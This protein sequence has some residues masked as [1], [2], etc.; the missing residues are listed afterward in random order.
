MKKSFAIVIVCYNRI[1]GVKR[2]TQSLE[3][4]DFDGRN[5]ID[6][7]FSI[8]NSGSNIVEKFAANYQ[9]KNGKKIIRT[10]EKRQG[11]KKH[12]LQCG[13]YTNDYDILVVLED[14]IFVSDSMYHFAY[15]AAVYYWDDT[16]VAGISLY[17]FQK[18][19]LKW[20][21]RFEPQKTKYDTY[22][23]RI[24]MSWGQVWTKPKWVAFKSWLLMNESFEKADDIPDVLNVWPETS[25]LKYH[26]L[27]CI[28]ENKYFVYPYVS[29]STNY[30]DVGEHA[31]YSVTDHQ[32]E[33]M[34]GKKDYLFPLNDDDAVCYDEFMEREG[35]GKYMGID[36][37][38]LTVDLW[39]NKPKKYYKKYVLSIENLPFKQIET[40]ALALRPI[41]L[42]VIVG[43][44]GSEIK[45]Y[46]TSQKSIKEGKTNADFY[47]YRYSIRSND[48][49]TL[50]KFSLMLSKQFFFDIKRKLLK[51][52]KRLVR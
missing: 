16:S 37:N 1:D 52:L 24:A 17:S 19:W 26:D 11:L 32:V 46:D 40:Y 18:N 42:S 50:L 7:I 29:I 21:V 30:S 51:I 41:E 27:Y 23:M 34:Y 49:S 43:L 14:D 28:R 15:S 12:I 36:D 6:L 39:G 35:L 25:W 45:L 5:D 2:L 48:Y 38:E 13:E 8:D 33:L 20:L 22:F 9:W 44:K 4:V 10:F 31:Q 3:R 47:R